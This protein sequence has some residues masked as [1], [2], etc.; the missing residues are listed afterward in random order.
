MAWGEVLQPQKLLR[1]AAGSPRDT[2]DNRY[3]RSSAQR[4]AVSQAPGS[5][6]SA[7]STPP[8]CF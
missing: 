5:L 2:E 3:K 1:P 6:L 8:S 4:L 7:S